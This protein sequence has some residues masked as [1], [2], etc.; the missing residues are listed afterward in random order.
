MSWLAA[1]GSI[2]KASADFG[3]AGSA[4]GGILQS[5]HHSPVQKASWGDYLKQ[6]IFD[7][8]AEGRALANAKD[9]FHFQQQAGPVFTMQGYKNAGINPILA[10][11]FNGSMP[12]APTPSAS[13]APKEFVNSAQNLISAGSALTGL[14][15]AISRSELNSASAES[16]RQRTQMDKDLFA[17]RLAL[18][19]AEIAY[20]TGLPAKTKA[21]VQKL[22]SELGINAMRRSLMDSQISLNNAKSVDMEQRRLLDAERYNLEQSKFEFD[23][24]YKNKYLDRMHESYFDNKYI[25]RLYLGSI[26]RGFNKF[27]EMFG[28]LFQRGRLPDDVWNYELP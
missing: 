25:G 12:S 28:G 22:Y 10:G 24:E 20:K 19:L 16:L 15:E 21:E 9:L 1:L 3:A 4:T 23:K 14:S 7:A 11:N 18:Q 2:A 26:A 6:E 8:R 13:P 17:G 27:A 5:I